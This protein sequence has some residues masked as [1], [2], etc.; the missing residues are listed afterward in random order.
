MDVFSLSPAEDAEARVFLDSLEE[1]SLKECNKLV[2]ASWNYETDIND[3]T[4]EI[5]VSVAIY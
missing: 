4:K 3:K 2:Q 5:R 1:T